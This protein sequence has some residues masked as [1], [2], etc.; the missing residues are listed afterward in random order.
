MLPPKTNKEYQMG[1]GNRLKVARE[2]KIQRQDELLKN[3]LITDLG[4]RGERLLSQNLASD[5]KVLAKVKGSFGQGLVVTTEHVFVVKWGFQSGSTFGGKCISYSYPNITGLQIKMQA[6]MGLVQ[7]LTPATRDVSNLS[8]WGGHGKPN[9][10]LESDNA[11]TFGR[12][13]NVLFQAAINLAK[14]Q[15]SKLVK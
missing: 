7:V 6:V 1:L 14:E 15:M 8:Y 13:E 10:A 4:R 2:S 12:H 3:K 11:V 5:E 9:S